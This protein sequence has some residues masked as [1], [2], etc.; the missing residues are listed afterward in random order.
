MASCAAWSVPDRGARGRQG[1]HSLAG[2]P[3]FMT[4][5]SVVDLGR[6]LTNPGSMDTYGAPRPCGAEDALQ[7][8]ECAAADVRAAHF[9]SSGDREM[10]VSL[11]RL[12]GVAVAALLL[13]SA[14]TAQAQGKGHGKGHDKHEHAQVRDDDHDR[15][16]DATTGATSIA[17]TTTTATTRARQGRSRPASR[18]SRAACRP[19]STRSST[20]R[21]RALPS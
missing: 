15:D 8:R 13:A 20:T 19:V 14:G 1:A 10:R 6:E 4:S 18:R 7:S 9:L 3:L 21:D 17:A 16:H 11:H 5:A 2:C 12:A